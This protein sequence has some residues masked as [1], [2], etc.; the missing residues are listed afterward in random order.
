MK[1]I[2]KTIILSLPFILLFSLGLPSHAE[3][4][5]VEEISILP[6]S[7]YVYFNDTFT[8][9][10]VIN[11][12]EGAYGAQCYIEFDPTLLEVQSIEKGDI[13][14][15]DAI[16]FY[17]YD[18]NAGTIDIQAV[19]FSFILN[20]S[21]IMYHGV[22]ANITFKAKE[23]VGVSPLNFVASIGGAEKTF[24]DD[25]RIPQLHNATVE[26]RNYPVYLSIEPNYR[27][28]GNETANYN[29]T[30]DP[31][32]NS[33]VFLMGNVTFNSEYFDVTPTNGGFF[34]DNNFSFG[35]VDG[36]ISMFGVSP[37]PGNN[38][39]GILL[40]L[41]FNPKQTGM[42]NINI[43]ITTM[44]DSEGNSLYYILQNATLEADLTPPVVTFEFGA[45]YYN[46][47]NWV[48]SSTPIYINATDTHDYTL[49]YRI[50]NGSWQ[51]WQS[52][53][54]NKDVKLSLPDEGLHYI[55]Y[56][57]KDEFNNTSPVGNET[58]YV[59]NTPPSSTLSL[60]PL[61]PDGENGW[62]VSDVTINFTAIDDGS[63]VMA[64]CYKI[65]D[66]NI[67]DYSGEFTV[68]EGSHTIYYFAVDNLGNREEMKEKTVKVD[69]NP[70]EI[71]Y[72]KSGTEG[73][74]EW[75]TST[76]TVTINATDAVSGI[77]EVKY[78]I[79][80]T[81]QDYSQPF[82]L[83][84]GIYTVKYFAK[85][86]AGNNVS[87]EINISVDT[88][89]PTA[90][91]DFDGIMEDGKYTTDVT[92]KL[93]AHDN[94]AGVKEIHYRL[95]GGNWQIFPGA[96]G[97]DTVS[98]EGT[99]TIEY[100]AVDNAGNVGTT[101]QATFTIEKNKK[102]VADF[103]YTPEEPLDT[104]IIT[105][106]D[107][108]T[109]EDGEIV[110]WFWEFG[111]G[112]TST[113]QN[114]THM[115][116]D[117]GTYVVKLTVTDDKNATSTKQVAIV[118]ANKA[119]VAKFTF[120][121]ANPKIGDEIEFTSQS[122]DD[123]GN[124]VSYLWDFGDGNTSTEQNPVHSYDKTGTYNVTLTVTDNDGATHTQT[125]QIEVTKEKVNIW[126]YLIIIVILVIIAIVVVAV[127][128]KRTKS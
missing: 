98:A 58:V 64:I 71:S 55:E 31:N 120:N 11:T 14:V 80:N 23:K 43:S 111:D 92:V 1:S 19:N 88:T 28:I 77:Q 12:T 35:A 124:I 50:W 47:S 39:S 37:L 84:D 117:N 60:N 105:F 6:Q 87:G 57:A 78:M 15:G 115:Y 49:Y 125:Q 113:N 48:N 20:Q 41:Q 46:G 94:L 75:Y 93:N 36:T 86:N 62:Y 7:E 68:A 96:S 76:V 10:V 110:S 8:V 16:F 61:T 63:G 82:T 52:E 121:P 29:L 102:P 42:T 25:K 40:H 122:F 127:W 79:D 118:V 69:K 108:S 72:A 32:G 81:W 107:H 27:I 30:I 66:G 89:K 38:E 106:V 97:T 56:Y 26:V 104:D 116:E 65:D 74:N 44:L 24:F 2:R 54:L 13:L 95:D 128:M 53:A 91:H 67:T 90:T 112:S 103:T 99:H 70:P 17:N 100:Y 59:D 33:I 45:P 119:P 83:N 101:N 21:F 5:T 3:N 123:D 85:D 34:S 114:P 109:D 4:G 126:L 9:D 51:G 18:N 73:S 22:L